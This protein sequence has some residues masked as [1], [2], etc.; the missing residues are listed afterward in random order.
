MFVEFRLLE[1]FQKNYFIQNYIIVLTNFALNKAYSE[2]VH[3]YV[4][5][6]F[7]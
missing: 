3:T 5:K 1:F 7:Y 6:T 2:T 4:Y